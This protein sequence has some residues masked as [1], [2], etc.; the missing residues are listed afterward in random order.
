MRRIRIGNV[1]PSKQQ[2]L[3]QL[4]KEV[5]EEERKEEEDLDREVAGL[6]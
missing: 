3:Q 1:P 2:S 6:L 4:R 5:F